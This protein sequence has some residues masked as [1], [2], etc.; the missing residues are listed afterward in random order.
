MIKEERLALIKRTQN[1]SVL[2]AEDDTATRE[3][4]QSFFEAIFHDV[5]ISDNGED[6][7][8]KYQKGNFDIIIV[9]LIMP[10]VSGMDLIAKIRQSDENI[11][12]IILSA[13][14]DNQYFLN[15]IHYGV[16]GYLIKPMDDKQLYITLDKV[17]K[18]I[19]SEELIKNYKQSLE[20]KVQKKTEELE[21]RCFHEHYT[22]LPNSVQLLE[23]LH[24]REFSHMLLL[25]MSHFSTINKE[26]GKVFANHVIVKTAYALKRHIHTKAELYKVESDRFVILL[27][28]ATAHSIGEYCEQLISF[29]DNK[30]VKVDEA[31][32]HITFNIGIA[33]IKE[34]VSET[35]IN[36][37]YALDKSK[38][39][40]SRHYEVFDESVSYFS[41][42]KSA[43]Q[44]L[45]V[46]RTLILEEK[47]MPYFQP[48]KSI[49]QNNIYK[50][51][52]LARGELDGE[53]ILPEDFIVPAEKL[54]LITSVT[55]RMINESFKFFQDK[56]Y[57]FSINLS[58]R[59]LL[60]NYLV[61]FL[62][63]KMKTY[64]IKPSRVT[65]EILEN[66]TI[67]EDSELVTGQL[68]AVKALGFKLA[69]DDFGIEN[70]NF[71]RMLDIDL[72]IIKIDGMF[73]K[74]IEK[75]P[76]HRMVTKAIVNLAK[77]M[78]IKTVAEYVENEAI[79]NLVKECGIDYAQGYFVGKPKSFL[80]A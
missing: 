32:L 46:A 66:V 39:L 45:R 68:N 34:D 53:I 63:E 10:K 72:D 17:V 70:S 22:D 74:D 7:Y 52:V 78:G 24:T 2:Y 37:E 27:K 42:E 49:A 14:S 64:N 20:Q 57:S 77:T 41:G 36:S 21:H 54:G 44:K 33:E 6:T 35:L 43:I 40:G 65:F 28:D 16:D 55:R 80:I 50:Y 19:E 26:Y 11:S 15:S 58:E 13:F 60:E 62:Q 56:E 67:S 69:I 3:T 38:T 4:S 23:D 30:N 9:D 48:I 29:F 25:D 76:K 79:Y 75:N 51:E 73:I 61:D 5:T 31:E 18:R 47:I 8:E 59:D 12:I 71:S 1:L